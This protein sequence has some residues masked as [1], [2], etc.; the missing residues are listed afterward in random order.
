MAIGIAPNP[1]RDVLEVA[2]TL[3]KEGFVALS[4]LDARGQE[5]GTILSQVQPKGAYIVPLGVEGFPSGSYTVR[6]NIDGEVVQ[7]KQV[8]I[9]Q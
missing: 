1:A 5:V 8:Q 7:T 2:Y 4:L 9:V 3:A 6:L